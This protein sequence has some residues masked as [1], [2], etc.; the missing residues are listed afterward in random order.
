MKKSEVIRKIIESQRINEADQ[1]HYIEMYCKG[2][3]TVND[4]KWI[5]E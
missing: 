4:I 5:W 2:W 1:A 3:Y